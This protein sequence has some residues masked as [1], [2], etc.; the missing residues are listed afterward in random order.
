MYSI[1]FES[2]SIRYYLILLRF[3]E[4]F[5]LFL[6]DTA[7]FNALRRFSCEILKFV[8][9]FCCRFCCR[10]DR[11]LPL[12]QNGSIAG[13]F[14]I[15]PSIHPSIH[16]FIHSGEWVD[17]PAERNRRSDGAIGT[18]RVAMIAIHRRIDG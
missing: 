6:H 10:S 17:W 1:P 4:F 2:S 16:S 13:L 5:C 15:H 3:T 9:G 11:V 8:A 7:P 12:E 18:D 14:S